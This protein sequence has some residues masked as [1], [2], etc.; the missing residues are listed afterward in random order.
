[1]EA[2]ERNGASCERCIEF[3]DEVQELRRRLIAAGQ[4]VDYSPGPNPHP[5]VEHEL[6]AGLPSTR[7]RMPPLASALAGRVYLALFVRVCASGRLVGSAR[8]AT[9]IACGRG[10][11]CSWR[12]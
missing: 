4:Y 7:A 8:S 10:S 3:E 1:V 12:S 2:A 11:G 6:Q 9:T 5:N